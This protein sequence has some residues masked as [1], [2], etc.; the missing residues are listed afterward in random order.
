MKSGTKIYATV[1][2]SSGEFKTWTI[3]IPYD[4]FEEFDQLPPVA[5]SDKTRGEFEAYKNW[6]RSLKVIEELERQIDRIRGG[7]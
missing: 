7:V 3:D 4:D 5:R 1:S 2:F 6:K